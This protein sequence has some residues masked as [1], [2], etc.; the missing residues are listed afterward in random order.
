MLEP[1]DRRKRV[2]PSTA[3]E[4]CLVFKNYAGR[5]PEKDTA[6]SIQTSIF[7]TARRAA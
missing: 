5:E 4:R 6:S 3:V 7:V 1:R 2:F